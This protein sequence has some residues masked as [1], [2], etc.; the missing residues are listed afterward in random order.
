MGVCI[1]IRL[2]LNFLKTAQFISIE[3]I[4]DERKFIYS[5]KCKISNLIDCKKEYYIR[6]ETKNRSTKLG[7]LKQSSNCLKE[8]AIT[9]GPVES[10][11]SLETS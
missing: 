4:Q 9:L 10:P 3:N 1:C 7:T 11:Y 6:K 2:V 5:Y 8:K